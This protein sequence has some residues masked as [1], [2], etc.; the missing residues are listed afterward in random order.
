MVKDLAEKL[1]VRIN[2]KKLNKR[3]VIILSSLAVLLIIITIIAICVTSK[4]PVMTDFFNTNK[5][6]VSGIDVSQH[7]G[8]IEWDK[9]ADAT[10]FAIIRAGYRGYGNGA[11]EKD[12][13]YK[14]NLK[15]ARKENMH[16]GVYFYSQATTIDEAEEEAEYVLDLI[17][18]Y[19]FDLPVFLD[20][21]YPTDSN[22]KL[23]GRL[24]NANLSGK[25][26]AAVINAFCRKIMDAGYNAG[27]YASSNV[28]NFDIKTSAL[29]D[30]LF[31]WVAD[32]NA[33]V[34]YLGDYDLWQ[35][36]KDGECDGVHSK[37]VDLNKWY[38]R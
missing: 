2:I 1:A 35:Y 33:K 8:K 27:I 31:I 18:H 3:S 25:E 15:N 34:T 24:Y 6:Y 11:L 23:T 30:E 20:F 13:R 16:I 14:E 22:G 37:Y 36:A 26:A 32:Y 9:V 12:T 21:E 7:N 28:L 10:D 17:R 5:R 38:I 29:D 19:D 4:K